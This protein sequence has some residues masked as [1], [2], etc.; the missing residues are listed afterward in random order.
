MD[1]RTRIAHLLAQGFK[2][3]QVA[4]I[5]GC[6]PAYI[7]QLAQDTEWSA[8]LAALRVDCLDSDDAATQE[9]TDNKYL[10]AEHALLDR[11][12]D[13]APMMEPNE[14]SRA[15]SVVAQRQVSRDR[16]SQS[17]KLPAAQQINNIQ[18]VQLSIPQH[19][20]PQSHINA[21]GQITSIN[22]IPMVPLHS[23][24]VKALFKSRGELNYEPPTKA[25][26]SSQSSA[27]AL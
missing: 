10:A 12:M 9:R 24:S 22:S 7:S 2:A 19:S 3:K 16:S 27:S 5:V 14:L 4:H 20:L 8:Q 6:T 15:L 23:D 1:T 21:D 25:L 17:L 11:L 18:V 13:A 26:T